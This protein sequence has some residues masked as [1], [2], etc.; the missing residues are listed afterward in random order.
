[1]TP[2]PPDKAR[3]IRGLLVYSAA[4][5]LA[6]SLCVYLFWALRTLLLPIIVGAL[7]AYLCKPLLARRILPW[8]PNGVRVVLLLGFI[9]G[10]LAY[11]FKKIKSSIF[12]IGLQFHA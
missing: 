3:R 2:K 9:G 8:L 12:A 11:S 6:V 7:L 5:I 10:G 1:M 4:F